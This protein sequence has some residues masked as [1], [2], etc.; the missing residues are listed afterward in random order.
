MT[1]Q[2]VPMQN[3][4]PSETWSALTGSGVPTSEPS[5]CDGLMGPRP[6]AQIA[7]ME[8]RGAGL[9]AEFIVPS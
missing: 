4:V 8:F 2:P 5:G 3:N 7:T 1:G 9:D 6:V